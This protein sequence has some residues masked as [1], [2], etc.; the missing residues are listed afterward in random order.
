MSPF[1]FLFLP[2]FF[3]SIG[4]ALSACEANGASLHCALRQDKPL[5]KGWLSGC[6]EKR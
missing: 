1:C 2:F 6:A 5:V 3:P 4:R